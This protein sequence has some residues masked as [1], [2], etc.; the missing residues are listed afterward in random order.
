WTLTDRFDLVA[1]ARLDHHELFGNEVSPRLYA[2]WQ[3]A[4][5]WTLKG[6]YSRGFTAPMLK[7]ISPEYR[8]DGPHSFNGHPDVKPEKSGNFEPSLGYANAD[9][10]LRATAYRN[11][12]EGLIDAV[13]ISLCAKPLGRLYRYENVSDA[14]I[15]GAELEAGVEL[16]HNLRLSGN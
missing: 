6:G 5:G 10:W 1:G 15:R 14:R 12:V 3:P 2:V 9:Y 7:Q 11:K 8:F 4:D 13:C 16:P